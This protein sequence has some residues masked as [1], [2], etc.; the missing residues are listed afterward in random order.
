[1]G[2]VTLRLNTSGCGSKN[3]VTPKWLALVGGNMDKNLRS[4]GGLILTHTHLT[5]AP[6]WNTERPA[7]PERLW[8]LRQ[9]LDETWRVWDMRVAR[10][11]VPARGN[12]TGYNQL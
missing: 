6:L 2:V 4:P 5:P 12:T 7:Q 3:G 8:Q 9:R 11:F 10:I 1:M